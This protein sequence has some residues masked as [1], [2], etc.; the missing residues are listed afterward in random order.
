ME[1]ITIA[2]VGALT[3]STVL[4]GVVVV[5]YRR[6]RRQRTEIDSLRDT[7][8]AM[9]R[10]AEIR[11][12]VDETPTVEEPRYR[13]RHLWLIRGSGVAALVAA[14]WAVI[15]RAV[16]WQPAM[17]L[18][19]STAM[20]A[21]G[22]LLWTGG[23]DGP[24][25]TTPAAPPPPPA[26]TAPETPPTA[27]PTPSPEPEPS[28]EP[29]PD[30]GVPGVVGQP[31]GPAPTPSPA[32]PKVDPPAEPPPADPPPA[33]PPPADPPPA[34]PTPPPADPTPTPPVE[35]PAGEDDPALGLCLNV[36]LLGLDLD[37]CLGALT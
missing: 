22:W 6:M 5:G 15:R 8:A 1:W 37:A 28:P 25:G 30:Q 12:S 20:L 35:P 2:A 26:V 23:P 4:L 29:A 7:L 3:L 33:D 18:A 32:P 17:G 19:A 11:A 13:R 36:S 10:V 27:D 21:G 9:A 14:T 16:S 34:V 31:V 24:D